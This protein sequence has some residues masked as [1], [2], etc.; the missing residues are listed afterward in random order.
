L[1][2]IQLDTLTVFQLEFQLLSAS[3]NRKKR[4]E[5]FKDL[6]GNLIERLKSI[7]PTQEMESKESIFQVTPETLAA[8]NVSNQLTNSILNIQFRVMR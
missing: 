8:N 2:T 3:S 5:C 7:N 4:R 1:E 6:V